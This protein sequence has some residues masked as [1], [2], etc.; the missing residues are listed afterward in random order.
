MLDNY[1]NLI[2]N[3][4]KTKEIVF[5]I[6]EV[7]IHPT[8]NP[9]ASVNR[10]IKFKQSVMFPNSW[11][12]ERVELE[13]NAAYL[14]RVEYTKGHTRFWQGETPGGIKVRGFTNPR[15]TVYPIFD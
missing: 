3:A 1:I 7:T 2:K 11:G 14:N 13:V 6:P 10:F 9:N 15:V 12:R 5:E 8:N 4:D